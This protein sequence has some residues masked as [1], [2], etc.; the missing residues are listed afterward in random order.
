MDMG[1]LLG[2]L[3][4]PWLSLQGCATAPPTATRPAPAAAR[5]LKAVGSAKVSTGAFP[6]GMRLVVRED[7]KAS[8]V[9]MYVS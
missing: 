6:S 8:T 4:V 7:P 1:R 9:S 3:L 2:L 5:G